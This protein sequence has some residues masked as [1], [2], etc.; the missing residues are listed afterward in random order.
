M[1]F[2]IIGQGKGYDAAEDILTAGVVKDFI[3]SK[4]LPLNQESLPMKC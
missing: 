1:H 3:Y 4:I 2:Q